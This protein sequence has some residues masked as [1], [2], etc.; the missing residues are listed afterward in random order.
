MNNP[1]V[2]RKTA[3]AV[4]KDKKMIMVR[5]EHNAEAFY[6]LGGTIEE[7]EDGIDCL[8]REIQEEVDTKIE[9][10]SLKLLNTFEAPAF[11]RENTIVNI[12]LY[13]GRL[14]DEPKPHDEIV[15]IQYFDTTV[16]KKHLT[17]ISIMMFDWLK[18]NNYIN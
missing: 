16:D 11:G 18:A 1:A 12:Q 15:E 9:E 8:H 3:L 5:E 14:T 4:F 7:D 6:T 2:I 13:E 17:P 10:G